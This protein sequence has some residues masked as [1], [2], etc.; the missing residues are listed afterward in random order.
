[1]R[2]LTAVGTALSNA[3]AQD[4]ERR[5]AGP[6]VGRMGSDDEDEED[7][8]DGD[9]SNCEMS[10]DEEE[11]NGAVE[12]EMGMHHQQQSHRRHSR[13]MSQY[14]RSMEENGESA[15]GPAKARSTRPVGR[16]E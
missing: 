1:M 11:R 7:E 14:R 13:R 12:V 8:E 9:S 5:K 15:A 4:F 2:A 16:G 10:E 6:E 3:H